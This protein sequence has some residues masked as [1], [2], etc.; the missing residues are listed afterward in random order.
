MNRDKIESLAKSL[1]LKLSEAEIVEVEN[2]F[3]AFL[4]QIEMI[5]QI[6]T[7]EVKPLNYPFEIAIGELREDVVTD[8]LTVEQVL[9]NAKDV[10][11]NMVKIPKVVI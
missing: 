6:D 8:V 11:N 5:N 4:N 1:M 2:D 3:K 10:K 9:S 7:S